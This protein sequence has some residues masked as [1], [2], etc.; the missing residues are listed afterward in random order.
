MPTTVVNPVAAP[1]DPD[2]APRRTAA[3]AGPA[4]LSA[5]AVGPA[6]WPAAPAGPARWRAVAATMFAVAWGG[7]QFTPLLSMYEHRSAFDHVTVTLLLFAYVVGLAP[8]LLAASALAAR[9]GARRMLL[10]ALV[11]S[12]AGSVMIAAGEHTAGVIFAGRLVIGIALG[13]GMVVGG[14]TLTRL[15]LDEPG[16]RAGTGARRSAMSLTAGFGIGAAAAGLVAQWAPLPA[17]TPY[18]LHVLVCAVAVQMLCRTSNLDH[19]APAKGS[20]PFGRV[21]SAFLL[22]V[23]PAAPLIFGALG[24]AYA[25]LPSFIADE[26]AGLRTAFA[27]F[28]C[29]LSL[30]LGF[31]TQQLVGTRLPDRRRWL[32]RPAGVLLIVGGTLMAVYLYGHPSVA[33]TVVAVA[34]MGVG[35]GLVLIGCLL[36]VE[37]V[38]TPR[39]LPLLTGI[40]YTLAYLGFG[41]PTVLAWLDAD[42]GIDYHTSL[43]GFAAVASL[44]VGLGSLTYRLRRASPG[45]RAAVE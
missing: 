32:A 4:R 12:A 31:V 7:N 30:G 38:A 26:I 24:I 13:I 11:G 42:L 19:G 2:A 45:Q 35:Y 29:L 33:L 17:R 41:I 20:G 5:V 27:A 16:A 9:F 37:R 1:T 28:L 34:I 18:L 3:P 43:L 14:S 21:P 40:T 22:L 39:Q 15:S 8:S 36:T 44:A 25:V 10:I 6:R 23:V